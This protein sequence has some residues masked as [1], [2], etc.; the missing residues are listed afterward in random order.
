YLLPGNGRG[1]YGPAEYFTYNTVTTGGH[2]MAKGCNGTAAYSAFR[3]SIPEGFTSPGVPVIYFDKNQNRLATPEVRL[4]P[5]TAAMDAGNISANEGLAG[6]GSDSGSDF[7][8]AANF[9]GTSAAAPHAAACALLI[10]Q[11]H[12]GIGSVTPTQ[13]M[14]ILHNTA[15]PHDLD[16]NSSSATA[17]ATNGGKVTLAFTSDNEANAG[18]G[19]NDPNSLSVSYV[20]P[21]SI[22][23]IVF[24][25]QGDAAHGGCVTCG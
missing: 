13:M 9:S 14:T 18:T 24:N 21:S 4:Q 22:A 3:P 20:G 6:L 17:R 19:S 15:F 8:V 12:G 5:S 10:L 16:P 1:G 2:A 7:D 11:A 25:P 23:S